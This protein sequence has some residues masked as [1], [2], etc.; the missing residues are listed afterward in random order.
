MAVA[1]LGLGSNLGDRDAHLKQ[2]VTALGSAGVAVETASPVYETDPVGY[3]AQGPFLNQVI[4]VS[5]DL[6]PD[7]LL[8]AAK[9]IESELGRT[10]TVRNGP[11]P[12]DI[13]ILL[14]GDHRQNEEQLTIPHPRLAERA[15]VLVPLRDIAPDL[16]LPDGSNIADLAGRADASGVRAYT[17]SP[18]AAT[19]KAESVD[20]REP[21]QSLGDPSE[22]FQRA[23]KYIKDAR[24][25]EAKKALNEVA[26]IDP[27][28]KNVPT[29][30]T[31]VDEVME[32]SRFGFSMMPPHI[33]AATEQ[34]QYG[35]YGQY[36][37]DEADDEPYVAPVASKKGCG[38]F[39][40]LLFAVVAAIAMRLMRSR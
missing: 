3:D 10:P 37:P 32:T 23:L 15:F 1:Y 8:M 14:Y 11:R 34:R 27:T 25:S 7:A 5:T 28:Y 12:I 36:E 17:S 33:A 2:A 20:S 24:W 9:Q 31:M 22:P 18:E 35:Q 13:D 4:R 16:T 26:A 38:P 40:L 21:A 6:S 29:L 19:P 39:V 30:Q